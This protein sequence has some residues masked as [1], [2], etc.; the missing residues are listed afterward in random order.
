MRV[1][2]AVLLVVAAVTFGAI[3]DSG[4]KADTWNKKTIVTFADSVEIP[5]QVLPPGTYVFKLLDSSANRNIVQIWTE[6]ASQLVATIQAV[7]DYR[8]EPAGRTIFEFDERSGDSPMVLHSWF[9]PGDNF[10]QRF[11]YPDYEYPQPTS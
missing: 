7:P 3:L 11:V 5:G 8:P 1:F 9:Y 4:A 10:G 2:K 6:D